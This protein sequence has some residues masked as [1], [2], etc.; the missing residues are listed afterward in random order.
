[1]RSMRRAGITAVFTG[2]TIN[3]RAS[4]SIKKVILKSQ[5]LPEFKKVRFE[6]C[7]LKNYKRKV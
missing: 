1:M 3:V 4:F 6:R 2:Q 5:F 7:E